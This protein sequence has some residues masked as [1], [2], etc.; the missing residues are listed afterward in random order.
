M[1]ANKHLY[2]LGFLI[3]KCTLPE[4]NIAPENGWLEDEF[5]VGRPSFKGCSP[6][7]DWNPGWWVKTRCRLTNSYLARQLDITKKGEFQ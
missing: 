2:C 3:L 7:G 1:V 4:T 5:L 6:G